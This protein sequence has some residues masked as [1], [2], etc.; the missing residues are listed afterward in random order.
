[1]ER[2]RERLERERLEQ[3]QLERERQERERQ[4]RLDRDREWLE[5]LDRERQEQ[6]EREQLE[7][8][9]RIP[10]AGK[11]PGPALSEMMGDPLQA[12]LRCLGSHR[13]GNCGKCTAIATSTFPFSLCIASIAWRL[14]E[15]SWKFLFWHSNS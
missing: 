10:S 2:E 12:C 4:E 6:L 13:I 8:E 14:T 3:E 7:R 1:M 9:R 11:Q 15:S 5:R